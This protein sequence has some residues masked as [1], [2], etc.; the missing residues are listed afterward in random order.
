M[1]ETNKFCAFGA[2]FANVVDRFIHKK[3]LGVVFQLSDEAMALGTLDSAALKAEWV[4][5][6]VKANVAE[7]VSVI[8]AKLDLTD[9]AIQA[10]VSAW[11]DL[12]P[13]A[14]GVLNSAVSFVNK[15]KSMVA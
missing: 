13:E 14:V 7:C 15:V 4:G 5:K 6:D 3:G 10:K 11:L 9:K 12:G 1:V 2:E 8:K